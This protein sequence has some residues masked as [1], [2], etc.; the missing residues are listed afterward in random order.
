MEHLAMKLWLLTF[1]DAKGQGFVWLSV[2]FSTK[3]Q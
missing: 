3:L 2:L 1:Y